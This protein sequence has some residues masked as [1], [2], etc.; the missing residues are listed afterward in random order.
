MRKHLGLGDKH[1][2][3]CGEKNSVHWKPN[4]VTHKSTK[5]VEFGYFF[6]EVCGWRSEYHEI[7]IERVDC[8]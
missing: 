2:P 3:K 6:C 4:V 7:E 8:L 1:C 5:T